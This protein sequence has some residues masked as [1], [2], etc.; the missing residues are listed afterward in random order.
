MKGWTVT[1]KAATSTTGREHYFF[2]KNHR[3]HKKTEAY[4]A[5]RGAPESA[6][7]MS[8][9]AELYRAK[10]RLK[11]KGGRPPT[12]EAIEFCMELPKGFR[13]T[14]KQW[15]L[16]V[17]D[18]VRE[19][20]DACGV[21]VAGLASTV[22][23]VVHQQD[24]TIVRDERTGRIRGS[25]D[26][27]HL[28]IGK[29]DLRGEYLRDLQRKKCTAVVKAAFNEATLTHCDFD[30]KEYARR[31]AI[32]ISTKNGYSKRT[33]K[34][35]VDA[36]RNNQI[37]K[38]N[39]ALLDAQ[40]GRL[41]SA[42]KRILMEAEKWL[43]AFKE[44]DMTQ[45]NRQV[46]RMKKNVG[47]VNEALVSVGLSESECQMFESLNSTIEAVNKMS[48]EPRIPAISIPEKI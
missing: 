38:D 25:G 29:F 44:A 28:L 22:R 2:D 47:K 34:W 3:N 43:N 5:V 46:N 30:W 31:E 37:V 7:W 15:K 13:P 18:V 45:M 32:E 42:Y 20:A 35:I 21:D 48:D 24:Q 23:A 33:D 36:K 12:S 40:A 17:G 16:I 19:V 9:A 4:L 11:R 39:K 41:E 8:A 26:H 14:A 10:Q 27:C 6:V 1:T